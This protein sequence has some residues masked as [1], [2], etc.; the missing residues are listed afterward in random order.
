LARQRQQAK[1]EKDR[2]QYKKWSQN[3]KYTLCLAIARLGISYVSKIAVF[4][5]ERSEKQ[6]RNFISKYLR[7]LSAIPPVDELIKRPPPGYV[8]PPQLAHLFHPAQSSQSPDQD[9][10]M[11]SQASGKPN[12]PFGTMLG[13]ALDLPM[14]ET[15]TASSKQQQQAVSSFLSQAYNTSSMQLTLGAPAA[16][17]ATTAATAPAATVA[18]VA[19][20]GPS[21]TQPRQVGTGY[22]RPKMEVLTFQQR[23][24][25]EPDKTKQAAMLLKVYNRSKLSPYCARRMQR[26]SGE[27]VV[28]SGC[29]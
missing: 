26:G 8:P 29:E 23:A 19:T 5:P 3:E 22:E 20:A 9:R 24:R 28:C 13:I 1:Q 17:T 12:D 14:L 7:D 6:V 2:R 21:T 27:Y 16:T 10:M 11:I 15:D 18:T 25:Q 4:L